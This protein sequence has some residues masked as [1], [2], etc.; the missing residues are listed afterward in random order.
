MVG[1]VARR[2][3]GA[4]GSTAAGI[5]GTLAPTGPAGPPAVA[6]PR[7][8][9]SAAARA[10]M[11]KGVPAQTA[12]GYAGDWQRFEQ[13]AAENGLRAMPA[14]AET[15]T[16]YVAWLT[17]TPRPRTGR[18]YKPSSIDRAMASIAVAHQAAALPQP[19][20]IGAR[21][22]LRGYEAELK[23][24]K[25]PRGKVRKAGAATPRVL[26]LMIAATD[27]TTLIGARD[28][29]ALTNGFA[30]AARSSEETATTPHRER[31]SDRHNRSW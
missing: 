10:A 11:A 17:V 6:G 26:R 23:T 13:W 8:E 14:S 9:L 7:Q 21:L 31:E 5:S 2:G 3:S 12:R 20:Q 19:A 25:D 18:P 22:V 30:L 16:E 28:A 29:A 4:A 1:A 24:T 27:T 15:L